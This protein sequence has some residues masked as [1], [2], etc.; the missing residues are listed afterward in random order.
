MVVWQYPL[1]GCGSMTALKSILYPIWGLCERVIRVLSCITP[2]LKQ[3]HS[4]SL[5]V[6]SL[7]GS[8][9]SAALSVS[10]LYLSCQMSK[11]SQTTSAVSC[12]SL[13]LNGPIVYKKAKPHISLCPFK[14]SLC[15]PNLHTLT[16]SWFREEKREERLSF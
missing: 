5:S 3:P 16:H 14:K 1:V 12:S 4:C 2:K 15:T 13:R 7:G 6:F 11:C 8:G 10:V 9:G